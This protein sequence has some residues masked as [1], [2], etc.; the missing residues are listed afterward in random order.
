[1]DDR[2]VAKGDTVAIHYVGK[3]PDE[4]VFDSTEGRDPFE[5]EA[6]G[7][8]VLPAVSGGVIGMEV[9]ERRTLDVAADQGYGAY[10]EQLV[11]EVPTNR[12]PEGTSAGDMLRDDSPQP[13]TWVVKDVGEPNTKLDGNHPLAGQDLRFDIELVEIR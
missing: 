10:D 11:I 4:T 5:F 2:K 3:L 9:G 7:D 12:L 1:M 6:G 8:Q 13:R